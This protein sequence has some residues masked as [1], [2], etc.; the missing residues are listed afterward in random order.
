MC[1]SVVQMQLTN[2]M[3]AI[4]NILCG[5]KP[6]ANVIS[7]T[8]ACKILTMY[9]ARLYAML[10]QMRRTASKLRIMLYIYIPRYYRHRYCL[11]MRC[12][13][14]RTQKSNGSFTFSVLFHHHCNDSEYQTQKEKKKKIWLFPDENSPKELDVLHSPNGLEC[15]IQCSRNWI[16]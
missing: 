12:L 8:R 5:E 15:F 7:I 14:T 1:A 4:S 16:D 2:K 11:Y 13:Y 9:T 6:F 10:K 3:N